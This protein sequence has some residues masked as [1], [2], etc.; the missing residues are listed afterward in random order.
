[1]IQITNNL[2]L[3]ITN[4]LLFILLFNT[5]SSL[6]YRNI[7]EYRNNSIQQ[8][9]KDVENFNIIY[10][11]SLLKKYKNNVKIDLSLLLK[12]FT[13]KFGLNE[14]P[15][16]RP[17]MNANYFDRLANSS[18]F[19]VTL[20][21]NQ[22]YIKKE[23]MYLLAKNKK[24]NCTE[25]ELKGDLELSK[26]AYTLFFSRGL[27]NS[28]P[29]QK[30]TNNIITNIF[31][32]TN[33]N[34][35]NLVFLFKAEYIKDLKNEVKTFF[36]LFLE[37]TEFYTYDS[38]KDKNIIPK[39]GDALINKFDKIKWE[40]FVAIEKKFI[41][42]YEE[43]LKKTFINNGLRIRGELE[44]REIE[45]IKKMKIIFEKKVED[46]EMIQRYIEIS[47]YNIRSNLE[48]L[49]SIAQVI[50]NIKFIAGP[51]FYVK[52]FTYLGYVPEC[53]EEKGL[54]ERIRLM[55]SKMIILSLRRHLAEDEWNVVK[56][57]MFFAIGNPDSFK[58]NDEKIG[59]TG[60]SSSI[61][62]PSQGNKP[63]EQPKNDEPVKQ[64]ENNDTSIKSGAND[65]LE[66]SSDEKTKT[67]E[68]NSSKI[69]DLANLQIETYE[70]LKKNNNILEFGNI[71][72]NNLK[73]FLKLCKTNYY[74]AITA[75][76]LVGLIIINIFILICL[77]IFK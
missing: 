74:L 69:I 31:C 36:D 66:Q 26:I 59:S 18:S 47:Y 4:V 17:I 12:D 51:N 13:N 28:D 65:P 3:K 5:I 14:F 25:N 30:E 45:A 24:Y 32:V 76:G 2:K 44:K 42:K 77:A 46:K 71:N 68:N 48:T 33:L 21:E 19:L 9:K 34:L 8:H 63:L 37:L 73:D 29:N 67:T 40:N 23:V 35:D 43:L 61:E 50:S 16:Q 6:T 60:K 39:S 10:K 64:P 57:N 49:F 62:N 20:I 15:I 11:N 41:E 22:F 27:Q 38:K 55:T 54:F 72:V 53:A 70:I 58:E 1:M 7:Y 52:F 56:D 75:I